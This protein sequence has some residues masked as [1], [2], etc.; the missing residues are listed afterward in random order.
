MPIFQIKITFL[1]RP[2]VDFGVELANIGFDQ[3]GIEDMLHN[4][5]ED[6]VQEKLVYPG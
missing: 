4:L 6:A 3:F 1:D 5:V 2:Q